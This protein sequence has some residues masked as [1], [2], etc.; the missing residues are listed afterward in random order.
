MSG[1]AVD[2]DQVAG[3]VA[4]LDVSRSALGDLLA[5][6]SVQVLRMH[7]AWDGVA[8]AAHEAAQRQW[9]DG[10]AQM[11]AALADMRAAGV[12][13]HDNYAAAVETNLALW[14]AVT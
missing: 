8:A 10:F 4:D 6:L 3:L 11:S 13:A 14:R 2:L 7:E 5:E 1:F 9:E 12:S